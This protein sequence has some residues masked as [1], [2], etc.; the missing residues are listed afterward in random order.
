MVSFVDFKD[1][2]YAFG[3][4]FIKEIHGQ[5]R[6]MGCAKE[7][8]IRNNVKVGVISEELE[9]RDFKFSKQ[10]YVPN[11]SGI[12]EPRAWHES[13]AD[14]AHELK[15]PDDD[16]P[17]RPGSIIAGD[18]VSIF[19]FEKR[20]AEK[21]HKPK[22]KETVAEILR[23]GVRQ[24]ER[25]RHPRILQ[26]VH[27]IEECSETIAFA[28]EP[29]MASLANILAYH[30]HQGT[31]AGPPETGAS[32]H[33]QPQHPIPRPP[34]ACDYSFLGIELK[35][36]FLQLTEALSFLHCIGHTLH[37]NVC[38]GSIFVNKKGIWKLGGLEF[39]ASS[40]TSLLNVV[41]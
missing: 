32:A 39:T 29:V 21:L 20:L 2:S 11:E 14:R 8:C 35:Y 22:R 1:G 23:G 7:S 6:N 17:P 10:N 26:V 13:V 24:L 33:A 16:L 19:V 25:F 34:H 15:R 38:P 9:K 30:E 41:T 31:G 40:I 3:R 36:G 37:H 27:A 4:I 18:E 5:V 12:H 28:T